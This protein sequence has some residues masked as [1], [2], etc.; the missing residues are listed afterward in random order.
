M[1]CAGVNYDAR[2]F[3]IGG[4]FG[5]HPIRVEYSPA[6]IASFG[7][8]SIDAAPTLDDAIRSEPTHPVYVPLENQLGTDHQLVIE[9]IAMYFL[10]NRNAA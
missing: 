7:G 10:V 4:L 1:E 3:T 6:M 9:E 8:E 2:G 5:G